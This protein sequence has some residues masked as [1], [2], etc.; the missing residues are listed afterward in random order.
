MSLNRHGV[1]D[2][3]E[4]YRTFNG[5]RFEAFTSF[6][7]LALIFKLRQ[8]GVRCRRVGVELFVHI[9]DLDQA[10]KISSPFET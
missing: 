2:A 6:P 9:L 7:S 5:Q 1:K 3:S 8:N 10:S 4:C